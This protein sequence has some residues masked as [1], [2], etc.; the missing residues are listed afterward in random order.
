MFEPVKK[1]QSLVFF[2]LILSSPSFA[3]ETQPKLQEY[4]FPLPDRFIELAEAELQLDDHNQGA[5]T[6]FKKLGLV[7][8]LGSSMEF[9]RATESVRFRLPPAEAMKMVR[10]IDYIDK[11]SPGKSLRYHC[12]AEPDPVWAKNLRDKQVEIPVPQAYADQSGYSVHVETRTGTHI[13]CLIVNNSDLP[14]RFADY[15]VETPFYRM[16]SQSEG[17]WKNQSIM[18]ADCGV[19]IRECYELL[20]HHAR[21]FT[22]KLPEVLMGEEVR[23]P[24]R[25]GIRL[26]DDVSIQKIE[27]TI[28]TA[29]I[30]APEGDMPER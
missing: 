21:R 24:I 23:Y 11:R 2:G 6:V 20:P 26:L 12:A 28:W 22:V 10:I 8:P 4:I 17:I 15:S 7:P 14:T 30:Q 1:I 3:E 25:V 16:Q 27:N 5:I 19:G 18:I 13:T 9:D 29:P